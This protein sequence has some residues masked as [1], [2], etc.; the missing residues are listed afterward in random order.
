[1]EG[2]GAEE[3]GWALRLAVT[4][5]VDGSPHVMEGRRGRFGEGTAVP[6]W[7]LEDR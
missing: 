5:G 3:Q 4:C 6:G 1:M 2:V 7:V